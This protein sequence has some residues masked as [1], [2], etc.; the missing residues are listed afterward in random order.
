MSSQLIHLCDHASLFAVSA[1][2][3]SRGK[4]NNGGGFGGYPIDNTPVGNIEKK[5]KDA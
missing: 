1:S 2:V 4:R 3:I 5:D